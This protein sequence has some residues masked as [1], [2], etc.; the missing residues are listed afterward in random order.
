MRK[1]VSMKALNEEKIILNLELSSYENKRL[2][3]NLENIYVFSENNLI[4]ETRLVQRGKKDST[5]YLLIPR[6]YRK[7][8]LLSDKIRC[9]KIDTP[10]KSFL[11]FEVFN[12]KF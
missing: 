12:S 4:S 1:I 9:K 11:I 8:L 2:K 5:K 3:G 10:E 7:G 6:D